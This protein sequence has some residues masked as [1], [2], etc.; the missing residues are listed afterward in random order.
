MGIRNFDLDILKD[1]MSKNNLS[2]NGLKMLQLGDQVYRDKKIR[3]KEYFESLGSSVVSIDING[4]GGSLPID[5]SV[6]IDEPNYK[7][8]FDIIT[9]FGTSEHVSDHFMCFENMYSFCKKNGIIYNLVPRK[10]F[11][12]NKSHKD[13]HKY[14]TEFFV[15]W[16]EKHNCD[17]LINRIVPKK[18]R[19]CD[20]M[21][22]AI[23]KKR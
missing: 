8:N 12:N 4:Q 2:F 17:I 10:G 1:I 18:E 9:N 23:L 14:D 3:A 21:I 20:D 13:A 7:D 11:W 16:S 19:F 5:L 15:E 6:A 22:L